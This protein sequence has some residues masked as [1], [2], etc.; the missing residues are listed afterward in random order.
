[1]TSKTVATLLADLERHPVALPAPGLQ[2]Q[3]LLRG[4][5]QD[6]EVRPDLPRTVRLAWATPA[7]FMDEFVDCY[8]HDHHHTGI[9]L[10]TPAD[11]HYGLAAT[12]ADRRAVDPGRRPAPRHPER[13][14]SSQRPQDPR[15]ARRRLDQ[16]TTTQQ[17]QPSR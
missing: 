5:V 16:P 3:P 6:P 12:V 10:H 17:P 1:M 4:L 14:T 8:N 11:V 7:A 2:R 9:G 13:F 15:P